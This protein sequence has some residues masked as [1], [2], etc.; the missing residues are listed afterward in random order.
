VFAGI[1]AQNS[2]RKSR[3]KKHGTAYQKIH[4]KSS[5]L[6]PRELNLPLY[7]TFIASVYALCAMTENQV[8]FIVKFYTLM[9]LKSG[10]E[11]PK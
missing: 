5:G 6:W 3:K 11:C 2:Y 1:L 7:A 4:C 9:A 8:I 10:R